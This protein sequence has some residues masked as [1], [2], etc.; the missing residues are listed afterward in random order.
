MKKKKLKLKHKGFLI[1]FLVVLLLGGCAFYLYTNKFFEPKNQEGEK[2]EPQPIPKEEPD[3]R[4]EYSLTLGMVGDALYHPGAYKDGLQSDGT[5]NYDHQL[6]DIAPILSNYDLAYYN[7]E[8]ILGGKELGL[9]GYP[10]FNSP[11]EV[12]DAYIKAGFNLVSLANNHTMDKGTKAIMNSVAYWR[13]KTNVMTAGSYDSEEDHLRSHIGEKNGIKYAFLAYTYG[14]NGIPVPSG[15]SY[16]VNLFSEEQAKKDIESVK[17]QVDVILVAMHW[18][19]EYTHTPTQEQRNQAKFLA[20]LG[21]N[22]I[23]GSHPHVIEP[24]EHI[25]DTVVIYSLGNFISGQVGIERRVGLLA[26]VDIHKVVEND[27]TTITIDNVKGDLLYT[28][29][30]ASHT[31]YRVIPFYKLTNDL[32]PD[33]ES[34]KTKFEAIV[35]KNDDTILVGTLKEA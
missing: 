22:V 24:I 31:D 30:T 15:K 7:Q 3:P 35:N 2:S 25:G 10:C 23:I 28:Y 17:G 33:Y 11:Q 6:A 5:Y 19:V 9:S 13:D 27:E 21:V 20:D 1:G 14:T 32:L 8:T 26:S 18:G 34:I 29:H 16:L 12:G 4:Q